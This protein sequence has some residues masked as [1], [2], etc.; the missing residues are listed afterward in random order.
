MK[1]LEIA[2]FVRIH[3]MQKKEGY[4]KKEDI[5]AALQENIMNS[6]YPL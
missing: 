6:K 2:G 3:I 5:I 1:N 4:I